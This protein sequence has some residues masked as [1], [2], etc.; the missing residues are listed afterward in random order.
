MDFQLHSVVLEL[1]RERHASQGYKKRIADMGDMATKLG[2]TVSKQQQA[3]DSNRKDLQKVEGKWRRKCEALARELHLA[4]A[5]LMENAGEEKKARKQ[6]KH[7]TRQMAAME[8]AGAAMRKIPSH[9]G[10][11]GGAGGGGGVQMI[12][13]QKG[14]ARQRDRSDQLELKLKQTLGALKEE[15]NARAK[16][17]K[18]SSHARILGSIKR[19]KNSDTF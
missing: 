3:I 1:E 16:S 6:A 8:Q 4:Q 2:L 15:K 7:A 13:L 14:L 12:S 10:G 18:V 11:A 9:D 19:R 5:A 17:D